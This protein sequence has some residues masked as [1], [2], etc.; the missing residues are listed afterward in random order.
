[1]AEKKQEVQQAFTT[2]LARFSDLV[3][4]LPFPESKRTRLWASSKKIQA[5]FSHALT[6]V[7]Q[8]KVSAADI[9]GI[10]AAIGRLE[11]LLDQLQELIY[12][13]GTRKRPLRKRGE[14]QVLDDLR[15]LSKEELLEL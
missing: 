2:V 1:M 10:A 3:I 9:G 6:K 15:K 14:K 5:M 13:T 4:I 8:Q 7:F 11:T 12:K